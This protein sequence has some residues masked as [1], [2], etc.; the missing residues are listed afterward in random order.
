MMISSC[1]RA[2]VSQASRL[3]RQHCHTTAQTRINYNFLS[4]KQTETSLISSQPSRQ[5][6][7]LKFTTQG[8]NN[9][10]SN[11]TNSTNSTANS[12]RF[13]QMLHN[14]L[15]PKP[16]PP[17]WTFAWY[18]EV[19][20]ICTVFAITGTS[21]M[22]LVSNTFV[23]YCVCVCVCVYITIFCYCFSCHCAQ[24]LSLSKNFYPFIIICRSVQLSRKDLD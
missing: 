20:L 4:W 9:N 10:G 6:R 15:G 11:S 5:G 16:M 18:R 19:T 2:I 12:T 8:S 24:K 23:L 13:Q 21:T 14:F 17:R 3:P 7:K 22:V 1:T